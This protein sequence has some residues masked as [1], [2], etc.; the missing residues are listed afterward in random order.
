MPDPEALELLDEEKSQHAADMQVIISHVGRER[1]R[2]AELKMLYYLIRRGHR[3][4]GSPYS[5][6]QVRQLGLCHQDIQETRAKIDTLQVIIADIQTG[7]VIPEPT[8]AA[9]NGQR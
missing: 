7:T 6:D 5:G 8:L 3:V 1:L 2:L 9:A 4:Q